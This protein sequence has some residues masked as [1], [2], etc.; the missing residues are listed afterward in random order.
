MRIRLRLRLSKRQAEVKAKI[1]QKYNSA[2]GEK[3]CPIAFYM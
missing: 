2:G 1:E 3:R